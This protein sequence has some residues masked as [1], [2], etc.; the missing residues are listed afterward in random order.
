M[1]V[2]AW[3]VYSI[4]RENARI[5]AATEHDAATVREALD[6]A[7]VHAREWNAKED[8]ADMLVTMLSCNGYVRSVPVQSTLP[9]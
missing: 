2:N 3:N 7:E 9:F 4:V 8:R 5:V 1:K 6:A